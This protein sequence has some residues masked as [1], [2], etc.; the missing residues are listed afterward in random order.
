[1][2]LGMGIHGESGAQK[3]K[4]L[5]LRQATDL[6]F[7]QLFRGTRAL[8]VKR[9]DTVLLLV[10]NLG[11]FCLIFFFSLKNCFDFQVVVQILNW[12]LLLKMLLKI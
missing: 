5:P 9:D 8:D 1:M 7:G 3:L 10:N 6:A 11:L 2:E 12:V 4:L